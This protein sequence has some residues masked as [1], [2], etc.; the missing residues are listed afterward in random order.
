MDDLTIFEWHDLPLDSFTISQNAVMLAVSHWLEEEK[1]C[2]R[3]VLR[4][5]SFDELQ[6]VIDSTLSPTDLK[7][8]EIYDFEY[9]RAED[10]RLTGEI[11]IL[12]ANQGYWRIVFKRASYELAIIPN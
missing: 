3:Y 4:L 5:F 2:E 7:D 8:L 11:G 10:G 9:E 1:R 12:P 6:L